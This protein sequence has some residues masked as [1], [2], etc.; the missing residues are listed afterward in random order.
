[1]ATG[2]SWAPQ[3]GPQTA[4]V[5][6][7]VFEVVYGGAR[8]G[9]KTDA[10]LG[11]FAFH[12]EAV[13]A[14]ARGL[15]V[16]RTR[17]ALEPT[18]TRARQIYRHFGARWEEAKS[19]FTWPSGAVLYFRYLDR[20]SDAELYQGH[21]YT[22]VYVEELTQFGDP[23]VVDK[24]KATLR[25]AAGVNCG[26]RATC[27]PGGP[28]H[29]WVKARYIDP[30]PWEQV[31][32]D[33]LKRLF[34][35][36]RLADNPMLAKNDPLYVSRLKQSGSEA[37]VRAWLDGDWNVI[38]GAF[39]DKW[40]QR[41]IVAPFRIPDLWSRLRSFDWGYAAPFSV[42]WWAVASDPFDAGGEAPIPRGALVRYREWYGSNGRRNE[43]LR[44]DAEAVA[45]GILERERGEMVRFAV[46]D[47]SI[48]RQDGGPSIGERMRRR[49]S[50]LSPGRQY[51]GRP[52][53]RDERLGPAAGAHRRDRRR[54]DAV[55]V[56]H[57]PRLHPHGAGAAARR[58]AARGPG[59]RRRGPHCRRGAL[60]VP[61]PPA[62]R[63]A[64]GGAD[65]APGPLGAGMGAG[66]ELEADAE[67]EG[68]VSAMLASPR[69]CPYFDRING[70][71]SVKWRRLRRKPRPRTGL[72]NCARP[73]ARVLTAGSRSPA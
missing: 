67:L 19:R 24:L 32:E 58:A 54:A 59:H 28:G 11:E 44:L 70:Q 55:C 25:S 5:R 48:F 27:N 62:D 65:Q 66:D 49:A 37:L 22:R 8:G 12:A 46:A 3:P 50:G 68:V 30:G 56:R 26:F 21:D 60:R 9:G 61:Q 33:G 6:S 29:N 45:A 63:A 16:R 57:L 20:D 41:N 51:A 39:F 71:R 52:G 40:S 2:A 69:H 18:I 73:R 43:G 23:K 14:A 17:V 4:F 1:M 34:I 64:P 15:L 47:P 31:E 36:A 38:E 53:R 42:G 7:G 13:G 10:A 72:A 35:P